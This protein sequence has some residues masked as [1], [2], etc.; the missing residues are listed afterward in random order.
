LL[1]GWPVELPYLGRP[2]STHTFSSHD[3][4]HGRSPDGRVPFRIDNGT[5]VRSAARPEL[6]LQLANRVFSVMAPVIALYA[7]LPTSV[8][9]YVAG[10]L[11]LVAGV[12]ALG[13]LFEARGKAAL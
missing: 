4:N 7:D 2:L 3:A 13:L 6:R 1:A 11:F 12:V 9:I 10:A 5:L 8:P